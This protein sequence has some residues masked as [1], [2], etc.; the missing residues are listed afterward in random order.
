MGSVCWVGRSGSC[1]SVG[2]VVV[3]PRAS[4]ATRHAI[5]SGRHHDETLADGHVGGVPGEPGLARGPPFPRGVGNQHA[6][7]LVGQL[8]AR[9]LVE[10]KAAGLGGHQIGADLQSVGPEKDVAALRDGLREPDDAVVSVAVVAA[11]NPP[12]D[13][14]AAFAIGRR[15]VEGDQVAP[16]A[17]D[18]GDELEGGT[19]RVEAADGAVEQ[20]AA[21]H[22]ILPRVAADV[23]REVIQVVVGLGEQGQHLPGLRVQRDDGALGVVALAHRVGRGQLQI[24]VEAGD[25]ILPLPGHAPPLDGRAAEPRGV[26][27][28]DRA[29]GFALQQRIVAQ[30]Q[31]GPAGGAHEGVGL[32]ILARHVL[33]IDLVAGADVAEHLRGG[34]SV[35]VVAVLEV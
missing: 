6:A 13:A 1:S 28:V 22:D 15:A 10:V 27:P 23:G 3:S 8:D 30:L 34:G 21:I 33:Q 19:R 35:G 2:L 24:D 26:D 14:H 7:G 5:C 9:R 17:G 25:Q 32:E 12:A 4:E 29:A 11:K 18:G 31:P 16:Q 20:G